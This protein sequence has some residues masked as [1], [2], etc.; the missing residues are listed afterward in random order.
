MFPRHSNDR[1]EVGG[2]LLGRE[3]IHVSGEANRVSGT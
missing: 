2:C 1:A 3:L